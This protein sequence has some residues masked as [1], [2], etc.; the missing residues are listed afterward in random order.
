MVGRLFLYILMWHGSADSGPHL[1]LTDEAPVH[2]AGGVVP[3][4][5]RHTLQHPSLHD[6]TAVLVDVVIGLADLPKTAEKIFRNTH[7]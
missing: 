7:K 5:H 1:L 3:A 6:V 4:P 2:A